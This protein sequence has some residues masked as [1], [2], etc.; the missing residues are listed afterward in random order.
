MKKLNKQEKEMIQKISEIRDIIHNETIDLIRWKDTNE[1][2]FIRNQIEFYYESFGDDDYYEGEMTIKL[3]PEL[4]R[5]LFDKND[6]YRRMK[7]Y[8]EKA[9]EKLYSLLL[10]IDI[11]YW[12]RK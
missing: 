9:N 1:N 6:D 11:D 10:D 5:Y 8:L 2:C 3:T 7:R 12:N 4:K